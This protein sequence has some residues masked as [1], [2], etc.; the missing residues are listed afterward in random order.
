MQQVQKLANLSRLQLQPEE[1]VIKVRG[2][3]ELW[4]GM[5]R[6]S[7]HPYRISPEPNTHQG[8]VLIPEV[9]KQLLKEFIQEMQAEFLYLPF[10]RLL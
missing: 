6:Y 7:L 4:Y 10:D 8:L 5:K 9:Q 3:R 2:G 1:Y